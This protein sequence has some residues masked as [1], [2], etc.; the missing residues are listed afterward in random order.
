MENK[1]KSEKEIKINI[2]KK[3]DWVVNYDHGNSLKECNKLNI[4]MIRQSSISNE[5]DHIT[6]LFN[7]TSKFYL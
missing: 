2:I 1:N 6:A 7:K 3:Q 4:N 5:V